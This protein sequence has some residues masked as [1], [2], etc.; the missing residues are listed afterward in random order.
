MKLTSKDIRISIVLALALAAAPELSADV[1]ILYKSEIKPSAVLQPMVEKLGK[2]M[3]AGASTSIRMKGNKAYTTSGNWI[4]IFD[5]V[6]QEVT[7]ID[8]VHKTFA[9][10]P[11]SQIADKMAGAM[12]QATP[13][14]TQ[15]IQQALASIKTN[16]ASKMTGR[17]AEIQGIQAEE[18][19]ITVSMDIPLPTAMSQ[20]GPSLRLV[21]HLWTPKKEEVLRVAAIRELT[22]YQAW[23]KYFMNPT[24]Q[25]EKLLGNMPGTSAMIA[26]MLDEINKN[27][28]VILRNQIEMYMPFM[29]ALAKQMTEQGH[30][31][32]A[33]DPEAPVL[34]MDQEIAELS[35]AAVD[36]S[37]FEI[38]KD[39][40]AAPADDMLRDLLKAQTAAASAARAADAP[41]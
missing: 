16:V 13:E 32:P 36:A 37:L 33:I 39:Y 40:T 14:Q 3:Q 23:Q 24:G 17:T 35:S 29:V 26:P 20:N 31:S 30:A 34:E 4:Q 2:T 41:K 15:A 1:T 7:V 21:M 18:R 5:F 10:F 9:T 6:K 12:P 8:P 28:S 22:G 38:P 11:V 25:V 19:E 27:S